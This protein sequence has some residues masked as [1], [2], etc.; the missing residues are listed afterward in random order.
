MKE[1][2]RALE[3]VHM[4]LCDPFRTRS[5]HGNVYMLTITDQFTK[6][7]WTLFRKDKKN[8]VYHIK[9]WC[10]QVD[11]DRNTFGNNEKLL[12]IRFDRGTEFN[13][14]DMKIWAKEKNINLEPTVGY[15]PE[16]NGISERAYRTI[17]EKGNCLRFRA[18]LPAEY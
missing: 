17:L 18:G 6:F 5:W 2:S 11:K 15:R 4:D 10:V 16:V 3:R 9:K 12:F 13:N 1:V 8:L 7:V 14:K